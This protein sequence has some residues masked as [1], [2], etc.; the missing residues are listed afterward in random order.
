MT[1]LGDWRLETLRKEAVQV[2]K[3]K[4]W[5]DNEAVY[6]RV[7]KRWTWATLVQFTSSLDQLWEEDRLDS[8][9][10]RRPSKDQI[11]EVRISQIKLL[12]K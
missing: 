4:G 5:M 1:D 10:V 2:M 12:E 9:L 3:G 11:G 8:R 7:R 6:Q